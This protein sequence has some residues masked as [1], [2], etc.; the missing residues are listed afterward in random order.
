MTLVS[1]NTSTSPGWSSAG[2]SSTARSEM[3]VA[4]DQQHPRRIARPRRA[5]R[6]AVGRKLEIEKV[7]AH[8]PAG[9]ALPRSWRRPVPARLAAAAAGATR[10]RLA[11]AG[12]DD[13]G[14]VGRRL[15]RRD[16]VDRGHARDHPPEAAIFASSSKVGASM[17]KN[18][19]L[20]L[21]GSV[22]ARHRHD[23]AHVRQAVEFGLEVGKL[24]PPR[25]GALGIAALGHEAGDDAVER[26]A[27]VE[28]LRG[29]AAGSARH[30]SGATSGRSWIDDRA[31]VR[32]L[33]RPA[34]GRVGGDRGRRRRSDGGAAR[35]AGR[36][37][38][39]RATSARRPE[40]A[41]PTT[42]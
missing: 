3:L 25:A 2:R 12:A 11:E 42:L 4:L 13:L 36:R 29:S 22:G 24:E 31:A 38:L 19:L 10:E 14:R 30:G 33:Q 20:A 5:Q 39:R 7:D 27:V 28:A 23:A 9:W 8:Q 6:D 17:M 35:A 18:W 40:T 32:Q 37:G 16:R 15:A 41:M 34:V 1:L 21:F 26:Q